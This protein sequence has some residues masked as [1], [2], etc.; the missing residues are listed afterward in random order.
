MS[1]RR[2]LR[3][4]LARRPRAAYRPPRQPE[5]AAGP[6]RARL[7]ARPASTPGSATGGEQLVPPHEEDSGNEELYVVVRGRASLHRRRG[8]VRRAGRDAR[9]LPPET[10]ATAAAADDGT[11]VFVV[12]ATVG[13][14]F[15]AGGWETFVVAYAVPAP[16]DVDEGRA[17]MAAAIEREPDCVGA[18]V[19]R[20]LPRGAR[21]ERGRGVRYLRRAT[22]STGD[23][24]GGYSRRTATSTASATT[25]ASR[26]CSSEPRPHRRAR[27]RSRCRTASSGGRCGVTSGSGRSASTRTRRERERP[28]RRGAH[29]EA[30]SATRR[31]TS[32]SAGE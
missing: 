1:E 6:P 25:R 26:S 24:V 29:R 10:S 23:E 2:R 28:D 21:R 18:A 11:I 12:G 17:A 4:P 32:S 9:P 8:D 7:P 22:R 5:A 14:A 30:S 19:Q 20:R 31:S 15:D 16:G 3:D 27:R 13:K